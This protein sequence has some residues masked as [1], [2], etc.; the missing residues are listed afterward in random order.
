M[1]SQPRSVPRI[2]AGE[3]VGVSLSVAEAVVPSG[4]VTVA[5]LTSVVVAVE[6]VWATT[7]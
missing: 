3:K 5:V 4:A 2:R 7:V 1:L 6:S